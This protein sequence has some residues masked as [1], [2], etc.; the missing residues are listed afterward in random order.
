MK[1][2]IIEDADR[3]AFEQV[4]TSKLNKGWELHGDLIITV[5]P[6]NP[7]VVCKYIQALVFTA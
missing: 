5:Y 7:R 6:N 2:K 1:Y 3:E 4:V